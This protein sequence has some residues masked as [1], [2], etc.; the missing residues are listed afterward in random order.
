M[1]PILPAIG[2]SPFQRAA[3]ELK[4][5]E[6]LPIEARDDLRNAGHDAVTVADQHLAV[7][8]TFKLPA[9]AAPRDGRC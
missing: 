9:S 4:V 6:D 2:L 5:D 7:S 8:P 1:P 3:H